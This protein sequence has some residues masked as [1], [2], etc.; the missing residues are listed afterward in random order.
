MTS[1]SSVPLW[2][3]SDE[4]HRHLQADPDPEPSSQQDDHPKAAGDRRDPGIRA[5]RVELLQQIP[6][7][8][9]G[10]LAE[11]DQVELLRPRVSDVAGQIHEAGAQPGARHR[12]TEEVA[13]VVEQYAPRR[14]ESAAG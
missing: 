5:R 6:P 1:V 8:V 10:I 3:S 7:V 12:N 11:T 4:R 2:F 14:S 9:L 13:I